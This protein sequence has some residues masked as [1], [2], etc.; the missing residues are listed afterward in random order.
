MKNFKFDFKGLL[1]KIK[2]YDYDTFLGL[3]IILPILLNL[4]I[5]CLELKSFFKGI[6]FLF[7]SPYIFIANTFIILMTL[8]IT[9]LIKRRLFCLGLISCLWLTLG[10]ANFVLLCN[11]VT[12]FTPSDLSLTEYLWDI[13][14]K[15]FNRFQI[16]L[17]VILVIAVLIGLG[18]MFFRAPKL[19]RKI[20]YG[21]CLIF[22]ALVC[23]LTVGCI[24]LGTYAG[25]MD[26]QFKEL[27]AAYRKNGF[28]YCFAN[29]LL[30]N[31]ISKPK[32]YSAESLAQIISGDNSS[33]NEDTAD[34]TPNIIIVQLESFFDFTS[35]EGIELS[36]DLIPNFR[37]YKE[38]DGGLFTVPVIGAGTVN[39]EFEVVT[40]MSL[41]HFGAGEYPYK[42]IL[43][44][45]TCESIAY[46]LRTYGYKTHFMHNHTGTF[47]V[48]N[49]VYA[50][51][52]FEDFQ[53]VE[54][55]Q[56][57]ERNPM[58]WA[59]DSILT[60]YIMEYLTSTQKQDFVYTI[61]VQ[62]HGKYQ[63]EDGYEKYVTVE[64]C[65]DGKE[66]YKVQYEY[67]ANLIYEMDMFVEELVSTLNEFPEDTILVMY[68]DHLPSL[69]IYTEDLT[70]RTMYQTDYF[71]W[72]NMGID[73]NL[74][75]ICANEL[76]PLI[77]KELGM[78]NGIINSFH[79]NHRGEAD[80]DKSLEALSYDVLY[81]DR[82]VYGGENPYV[83]TDI[84]LGIDEILIRNV[85]PDPVAE[86]TYLIIGENFTSYSKVHING[87]KH[88]T[89]Y[90]DKN[91]LR[92][93]LDEEEALVAGDII[94]VWQSSLSCT[95]E[96]TYNIIPMIKVEETTTEDNEE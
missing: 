45:T 17:I 4:I 5:T 1:Q 23:G 14:P 94:T 18:I 8:S 75:D 27:S 13:L 63:V 87:E 74:G 47:Y 25:I 6:A 78:T 84:N 22:I 82:L 77:L 68:G 65:P 58:G 38:A 46:N 44:E 96:Y 92:I 73:F 89:S 24:K 69:D 50:N 80:F 10:I 90:I 88:R 34:N 91:T 39:T 28:V 61:S 19:Q 2:K 43:L 30:D 49:E 3:Y 11:R 79:Q 53:S 85:L 37:K 20:H 36:E 60:D 31:G 42:T 52:G 66:D 72:N 70:G 76:S 95:D 54:Y 83:A 16:V 9:L 57:V 12:P 59:K 55:M 21:R 48:R 56:N 64:A 26:A 81:G 51:L 33:V 32:D 15:Y 71:I 41:N 67:Y 40:G 35:L 7:N 62:G 86:N 93:K 29:S